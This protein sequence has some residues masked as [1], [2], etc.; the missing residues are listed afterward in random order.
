[1]DA[2]C[3]GLAKKPQYFSEGALDFPG[4]A[5]APLGKE[6]LFGL[7]F[8]V[9]G[10]F[11][12]ALAD[13]QKVCALLDGANAFLQSFESVEALPLADFLGTRLDVALALLTRLSFGNFQASVEARLVSLF[14]CL[15]FAPAFVFRRLVRLGVVAFLFEKLRHAPVAGNPSF[16]SALVFAVL[17]AQRSS[18]CRALM[19]R[20]KVFARLLA[21]AA[22]VL[23][24]FPVRADFLALLSQT[25]TPNQVLLDSPR[26][27]KLAVCARLPAVEAALSPSQ[28]APALLDFLAACFEFSYS[29]LQAAPPGPARDSLRSLLQGFV[30][31]SR[32]FA[33][34]SRFWSRVP[35]SA[36]VL[37]A[38]G[39]LLLALSLL[40]TRRLEPVLGPG[41]VAVARELLQA[42][43]RP[44]C[45]DVLFA[46][47]NLAAAGSFLVL[48]ARRDCFALLLE[49]LYC[50]EYSDQGPRAPVRG[51][52]LR[53]LAAPRLRALRS[54]GALRRL[55][56][57]PPSA[58]AARAAPQSPRRARG[59]LRFGARLR[60]F[61][62][63][64]LFRVD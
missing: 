63:K 30:A 5:L 35:K 17:F 20:E 9:S 25:G 51:S 12:M 18:E 14:E 2:V 29:E 3:P 41:L 57:R 13:A 31:G 8:E 22:L 19:H 16:H 24:E 43:H 15:G 28:D 59:A 36:F 26:A 33:D 32:I 64:R 53:A 52:L 62:P 42:R 50:D 1:M 34:L 38:F 4:E 45:A 10:G 7:L 47:G 58:S 44:A 56:T 55:P 37:E 23:A 49:F 40:D 54:G 48:L 11:A 6:A 46:L 21:D 61:L 39:K 27:L 60:L